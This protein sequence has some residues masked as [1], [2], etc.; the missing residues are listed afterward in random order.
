M[1]VSEI[2]IAHNEATFCF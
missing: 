2:D 1:I